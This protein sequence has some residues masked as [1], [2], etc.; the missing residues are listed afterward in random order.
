[1][2]ID[3]SFYNITH[4]DNILSDSLILPDGD[5]TWVAK[6][7][8]VDVYRVKKDQDLMALNLGFR[9][10]QLDLELL[11]LKLPT[12]VTRR[13][14]LNNVYLES[15]TIVNICLFDIYLR[16][17]C[18]NRNVCL[19]LHLILLLKIALTARNTFCNKKCI[20]L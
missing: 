3:D 10:S 4:V 18:F 15:A 16:C 19:F 1:M 17:E 12:A 14:N 9:D 13:K 5:V 20:I 11:W 2:L 8:M 7:L 6:D